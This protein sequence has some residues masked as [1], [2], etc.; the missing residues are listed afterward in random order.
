MEPSAVPAFFRV[1]ATCDVC[2]GHDMNVVHYA[3][4]AVYKIK[5]TVHYKRLVMNKNDL[6]RPLKGFCCTVRLE[7]EFVCG[8][9]FY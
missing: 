4:F 1:N 6:R 8:Q 9:S 7:V 2:Y 5:F 3:K